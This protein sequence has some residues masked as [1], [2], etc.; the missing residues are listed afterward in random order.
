M[1]TMFNLCTEDSSAITLYDE[2]MK[3][4]GL[5][6]NPSWT[7]HDDYTVIVTK[8]IARGEKLFI[9]DETGRVHQIM[10]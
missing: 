5:D 2:S 3:P 8:V 6:G 7:F 4:P 9:R 10:E 1:G